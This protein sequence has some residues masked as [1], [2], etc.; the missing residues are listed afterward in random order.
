M[1]N[2]KIISV[3]GS[4][5]IP[6]TGFDIKFLKKFRQLI[7]G[8]VKK[9]E[10]FVLVIGG[11]ATCRVYQEA[12]TSVV[13]LPNTDLH[14]LGIYTTWYNAEFVR[15]MFGNWAHDKVI[16]D[17][18]QKIKTKKPIVI[19]GGWEP[20]FSTDTDSVILAKQFGAKELLN[21]S[22]IDYV[23]DKDPRKFKDAKKI[24]KIGWQE[25]RKKIVGYKWLPGKNSPFDPIASDLAQEL[26]L[27][28]S[29][30]N[31]NNLKE[32]EKALNCKPFKGTIIE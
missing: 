5:I 4:I 21:L 7:L 14:W 1:N 26:G 25:F 19:A 24:E 18:T 31:G 28:V 22:N 11:G 3:G 29:V 15:L 20:G 6:K 2:Y 32:V 12:L 10:K 30:L 9:G 13:K 17:P 23:Y 16:K 8:R 27:K